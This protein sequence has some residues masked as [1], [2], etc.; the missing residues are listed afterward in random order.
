VEEEM[1]TILARRGFLLAGSGLAGASL[2]AACGQGASPA[3]PA[4]ATAGAAK[5]SLNYWSHQFKPRVDLDTKYFADFKQKYPNVT[6][7]NYDASPGKYEDKLQT[8]MAAGTGPDL[9]NLF[10]GLVP[11]F[12]DRGFAAEIDY[13]A[14]GV[15]NSA[16]LIDQYAWKGALE[17]WQWKGKYY[18]IPNEVSNYC[19]HINNKLFAAA[20][21]DPEKD[22]PKTWDD[23]VTVSQKLTKRDGGNLTQRGWDFD[24]TSGIRWVLVWGGMARQLGDPIMSPDGKQAFLN[25]PNAVEALTW[26]ADWVNKYQL[27]GPAYQSFSDGFLAGSV[28]MCALGSWF[29]PNW[30]DQNPDLYQNYTVK[31]FPRFANAKNDHGVHNYAYSHMVNP[32]ASPDVQKTAWQ[33]AY[34]LD[35]HPVQYL[36]TTGLLVPKKELIDSPEFKSVKFLDVFVSDMNK[37]TYE[38]RSTQY[39]EVAEAIRRGIDR[40]VT[41]NTAPQASLDQ[42]QKEVEDIIAGK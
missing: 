11:S 32:K 23:M 9:Y 17:G 2:L 4:Q 5:V 38:L 33:L 15:N 3:P 14:I 37:G 13:L 40:V 42:T 36:Q 35:S 12:I 24:Y 19:T 25:K 30:K 10:D 21:L 41:Q 26:I 22:W 18:G 8:A 7:I 31:A 29:A 1:A 16:A 6:D 20:S 34:F 39:N 28:A 27:G